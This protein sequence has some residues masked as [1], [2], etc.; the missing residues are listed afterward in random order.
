DT[1][2]PRGVSESSV[3]MNA[4]LTKATET[5]AFRLPALVS[6]A[7][8]RR[9]KAVATS[10]EGSGPLRLN[11]DHALIDSDAPKRRRLKRSGR[12]ILRWPSHPTSLVPVTPMAAAGVPYTP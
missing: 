12:V 4:E 7:P 1:S 3:R 5:V 9:F 8:K 11:E 6:L 2:S 10:A